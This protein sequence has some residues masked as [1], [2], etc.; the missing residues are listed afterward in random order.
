MLMCGEA[1]TGER[2]YQLG[3]VSELTEERQAL[4][5]ALELASEVTRMPPRALLAIKRVLRQGRD[6]P[7][8]EALQLEQGEFLQLFD[9]ADQTEGMTAFLEKRKPNF[10]GN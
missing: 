2:A 4:N 1:L 7:L 5:R 9:T 3:L 8:P 6:L 10:T